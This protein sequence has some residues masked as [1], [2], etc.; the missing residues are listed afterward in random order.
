MVKM[1]IRGRAVVRLIVARHWI[2]RKFVVA[3][4]VSGT[5]NYPEVRRAFR[6]LQLKYIFRSDAG[7]SCE[8]PSSERQCDSDTPFGGKSPSG[9]PLAIQT[10]AESGC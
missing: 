7:V 3:N 8:A 6:H 5:L 2:L 9:T 10:S 1:M 4:T